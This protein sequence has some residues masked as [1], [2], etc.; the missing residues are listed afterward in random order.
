MAKKKYQP[1]PVKRLIRRE[2]V[3]TI[4]IREIGGILVDDAIAMLNELVDKYGP[5]SLLEPDG[6]P[7]EGYDRIEVAVYHPES[8]KAYKI[9][10]AA[11][12]K[13]R[14]QQAKA[15]QKRQ[16]NKE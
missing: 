13:R 8:N 12:L 10:K 6:E 7:Y 15:R 2:V 14:K 11:I 1:K 16:E 4:S 9:R 3:Q 5:E